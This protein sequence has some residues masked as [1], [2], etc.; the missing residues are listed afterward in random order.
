MIA[1][2]RFHR[3]RHS[4]RLVDAAEVV[5]HEVQRNSVSMYTTEPNGFAEIEPAQEG[6]LWTDT[7]WQF[8]LWGA[9][10][11][12]AGAFRVHGF[13]VEAVFYIVWLDP[14]HKLHPVGYGD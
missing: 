14:L 6:A 10:G 9:E 12:T 8:G 3:W 13:I 2:P 7:P 11:T 1:Q 4:Q 5:M